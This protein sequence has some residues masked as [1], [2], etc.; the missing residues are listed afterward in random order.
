MY[1][2]FVTYFVKGF[3]TID[4]DF[5]WRLRVGGIIYGSGIPKTD[6]F[7]YT[8][9]SF[10][11]VDHSWI[12]SL[13][14]FITY[15]AFKN[16]FMSI[17][18]AFLTFSALYLSL[19]RLNKDDFEHTDLNY[20]YERWLHPMSLVVL[21]FLLLFF[22]VRAQIISWFLFAFL[23]LFLFRRDIFYRFRFF[24]PLL[25]LVWANLHGGYSIGIAVLIYF[26]FFRMIIN[27]KGSWK[28]I[29]V[30]VLCVLATLA[31]PYGFSDWRE[32][33]S[34]VFDSRLRWSIA[35]W[36]PSLTYFDLSMVFYIAMSTG[37]L[38]LKGKSLP[39]IQRYLFWILLLLGLSSRRNMPYF[40]IY[41]LPVTITSIQKLYDEIKGERL[42][43][44]RFKTGFEVIRVFSLMIL[45][46]QMYFACW[47]GLTIGN[48]AATKEG[49][50]P[51]SAVRYLKASGVDGEIFSDYGWGGYLIWKYPQ[52]KVFIDGRMPSWK[53]TPPA[54][55]NQTSSAYD[56]YLS[57]A[58]GDLDFNQ[59]SDK[60]NI[61]YVLWPQ[62]R[63]SLYDSIENI[64]R[65]IGVFG[66]KDRFSFTSYLDS[67]GWVLVYS[68]ETA[69]VYK[70]FESK[71]I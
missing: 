55:S 71:K 50:Y 38:F 59:V 18:L 69:L 68:D 52:K 7:S 22:S 29:A 10:P 58:S 66:E 70:R 19:L 4:P 2:A 24:L 11:F 48:K 39:K 14:I 30:V 56:D 53:F 31:T 45:L 65:N 44:T 33:L 12:F 61:T 60:Y 15:S 46:F 8:M 36:L 49:F 23:N 42:S 40:M 20:A 57:I 43:R 13:L 63:Y 47:R 51:D 21:A 26:V 17:F 62:H 54:G 35:E 5:G 64:F 9:P 6:P 16:G 28:E 1:F 25:F 34:S 37:M 41:S 3:Y 67:H 27:K 32:V